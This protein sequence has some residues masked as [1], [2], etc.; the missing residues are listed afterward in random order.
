VRIYVDR[1]G[2]VTR[3]VAGVKGST[4]MDG[5]L[6]KTAEKAALQSKFVPKE[7]APDEQVGTITYRFV[8]GS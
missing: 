5:N 7:N 6:W 1:S 4:T 8:R 3:A 2:R